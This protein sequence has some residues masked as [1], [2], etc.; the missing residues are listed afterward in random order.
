[1]RSWLSFRQGQ[2]YYVSAGRI[3]ADAL[4]GL[5]CGL[6]LA[7]AGIFMVANRD[8]RIVAVALAAIILIVLPAVLGRKWLGLGIFGSAVAGFA[9]YVLMYIL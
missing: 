1:M 8:E 6:L 7:A 9:L 4:V 2:Q 3:W 5:L